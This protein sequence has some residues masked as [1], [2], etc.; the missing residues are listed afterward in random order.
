[1]NKYTSEDW[2]DFII[3]IL[4]MIIFYLIIPTVDKYFH[5]ERNEKTELTK[6]NLE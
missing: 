3:V 4:I 1:M 2:K 6:D 5:P